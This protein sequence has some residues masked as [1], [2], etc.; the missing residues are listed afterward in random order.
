MEASHAADGAADSS[1]PSKVNQPVRVPTMESA[2]T[3]TKSR[4]ASLSAAT[5]RHIT[6]DLELHDVV[7]HELMPSADV[8]VRSFV[9]KF[10][11]VTVTVPPS[12][13]ATLSE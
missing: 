6:E 5:V 1:E 3:P 9:R 12:V 4:P 13:A 10:R 11:P 8:G 7:L 2:V